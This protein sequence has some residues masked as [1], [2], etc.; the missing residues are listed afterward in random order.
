[1]MNEKL[2]QV[3]DT[4]DIKLFEIAGTRIT[5]ATLVTVLAVV[6]ATFVFSR[7]IRTA[8]SAAFQRRGITGSGTVAAVNRLIHYVVMFVGLG[9]V[10]FLLVV[11]GHAR[12]FDDDG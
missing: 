10:P 8:A 7:L 12:A 4:L 3:W 6:V 9:L 11:L 5:L 2:Q 1:M